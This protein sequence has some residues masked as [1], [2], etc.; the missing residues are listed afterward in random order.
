MLSL[1]DEIDAD[2]N[3]VIF[4]VVFVSSRT[5]LYDDVV[6]VRSLSA[7]D[8]DEI[9]LLLSSSSIPDSKRNEA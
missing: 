4:I 7:L 3:I 8:V 5:E 2:H 1:D 6:D 9:N